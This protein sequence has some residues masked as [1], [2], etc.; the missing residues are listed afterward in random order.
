MLVR[1]LDGTKTSLYRSHAIIDPIYR[2]V[3]VL[4]K[5]LTSLHMLSVRV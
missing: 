5:Y 1:Y 3:P 2:G 4:S